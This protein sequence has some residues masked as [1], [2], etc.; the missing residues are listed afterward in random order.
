MSQ[1]LAAASSTLPVSAPSD[2]APSSAPAN[3]DLSV[4][5]PQ[6]LPVQ[7]SSAVQLPTGSDGFSLDL[8]EWHG[9]KKALVIFTSVELVTCTITFVATPAAAGSV[10]I[11]FA[12]EAPDGFIS[13][14]CAP[15]NASVTLAPQFSGSI[16]VTLPAV[17]LFGSEL[18]GPRVGRV[19][20]TLFCF[21][22][23]VAS[24]AGFVSISMDLL[25]RAHPRGY[26]A[27]PI[28]LPTSPKAKA[29]TT[30]RT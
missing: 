1:F 29:T 26:L 4:E 21:V 5:S 7:I 27:L 8:A 10:V 16:S 17:N 13:A 23:G 3:V 11:G 9:L 30:S 20:P 14:L 15:Y 12:R 19:R 6:A 22:D 24:A 28:A 18:M 2:P 25:C